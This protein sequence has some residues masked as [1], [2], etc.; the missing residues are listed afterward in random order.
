MTQVFVQEKNENVHPQNDKNGLHLFL[1]APNWKQPKH[2]LIRK[3]IKPIVLY[4]HHNTVHSNKTE[5]I[6]KTLNNMDTPQN[7]LSGRG[8][9][10]WQKYYISSSIVRSRIGKVNL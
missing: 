6:V 9:T 2:S 8:Q 10:K 1:I 7:M 4:Y 5:Q 3:W